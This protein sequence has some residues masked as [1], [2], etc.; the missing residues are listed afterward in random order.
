M[1]SKIGSAQ[2]Q[3]ACS[4]AHTTHADVAKCTA[5]CHLTAAGSWR[6]S[7]PCSFPHGNNRCILP[8]PC[9]QQGSSQG[10]WAGTSLLQQLNCPGGHMGRRKLGA[11]SAQGSSMADL[12]RDFRA[13]PI[14]LIT[15]SP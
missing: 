2:A 15:V 7:A 4:Q 10:L 9:H 8:A 3:R 11:L 1:S 13:V 5:V 6:L 14:K 12:A